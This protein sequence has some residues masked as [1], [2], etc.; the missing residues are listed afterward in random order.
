MKPTIL[1]IYDKLTAY[2]KENGTYT[3]AYTSSEII[4]TLSNTIEEEKELLRKIFLLGF[5]E[6]QQ[7]QKKEKAL[8]YFEEYYFIKILCEYKSNNF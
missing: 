3:Y 4:D 8:E 5:V 6:G 2:D 7:L 1:S